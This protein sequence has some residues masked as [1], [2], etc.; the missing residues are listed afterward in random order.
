MPMTS[1]SGVFAYWTFSLG[2]AIRTDLAGSY[3]QYFN[4]RKPDCQAI[5]GELRPRRVQ[6]LSRCRSIAQTMN[7]LLNS[8]DRDE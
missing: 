6:Q 2:G 8:I 3:I 5:R 1:R 7:V 4:C